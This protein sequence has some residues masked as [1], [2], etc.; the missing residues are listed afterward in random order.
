MAG[1]TKYKAG[2]ALG[3]WTLVT[4]L[5]SGGN[6]DVWQAESHDGQ[7]AAVKVL[8]R[9]AGRDYDRFKREVG[10][11]ETLSPDDTAILPVL[12]KHLPEKP[13]AADRPWFVMPLASDLTTALGGASLDVKVAAVRDVARTLARLLADHGI[14][15]RDVKPAN[16]YQFKDRI[17]VGD[18]GLAKRP[19]DPVLTET[20][21][22]LGP[23]HHLPSEV[24]VTDAEPNWE[25]VDV[26]CLS[27]TLWCIA[28][29]KP[30]PPRGQIRATEEDSLTILLAD[31]PYVGQLAGLIQAGTSRSP[32]SRPTLSD[33]AD[34]LND[35]LAARARRAAFTVEFESAEARRSAV[36]RWLVQ[37]VRR[38][39]VLDV[40]SYEI[41]D[42]LD[43]PSD[44]SGLTERHV[45]EALLELIE[46]GA[47]EGQASYAL[48]RREPVLFTRLYPTFQGI[49]EID[50]V[51]SLTAQATPMLRA[52]LD[53]VDWL[54]L[55]RSKVPVEIAPGVSL[56]PPEAY[57]QMRLLEAQ[58][59][60]SFRP[61]QATFGHASFADLRTTSDGRRWLYRQAT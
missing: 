27:N 44:V 45:C 46:D 58:G 9:T 14:S 50:D 36:L 39:P 8:H 49:D 55:P 51:E 33:F 12:D 10:I 60:L 11:C 42:D 2:D 29:E 16:L 7:S 4:M 31:E 61:M 5:G 28:V 17:V 6:G 48:G 20:G 56:S 22:R 57:F 35:W 13:T 43:S 21:R 41:P 15:H 40:M 1:R 26:Y 32:L 18:F 47:V 52:Y 19:N 24:Y 34:Q 53:S 38:E 23:F 25:R 3:D 54:S 30:H 37:H 59:L